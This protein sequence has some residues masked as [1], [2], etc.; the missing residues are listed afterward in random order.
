MSKRH[1]WLFTDP[2]LSSYRGLRS[3]PSFVL[4]EDHFL[5]IVI[6]GTDGL[7]KNLGKNCSLRHNALLHILCHMTESS[8]LQNVSYSLSEFASRSSSTPMKWW[9]WSEYQQNICHHLQCH[10]SRHSSARSWKTGRQHSTFNSDRRWIL[11]P[12]CLYASSIVRFSTYLRRVATGVEQGDVTPNGNHIDHVTCPHLPLYFPLDR[13]KVR[14]GSLSTINDFY[15]H[16]L[17]SPIVDALPLRLRAMSFNTACSICT[18]VYPGDQNH[19]TLLT[20]PADHRTGSYSQRTCLAS[21]AHFAAVSRIRTAHCMIFSCKSYEH[22]CVKSTNG[23]QN[24][25]DVSFMWCYVLIAL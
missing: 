23:C 3:H 14:E 13:I 6:L 21:N 4:F 5:V 19:G 22:W 20:R 18:R 11:R 16:R 10:G 12:W 7:F 1:R 8:V 17:A 9:V 2:P 15:L 24:A 25:T